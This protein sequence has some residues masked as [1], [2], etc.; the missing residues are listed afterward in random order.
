MHSSALLAEATQGTRVS[1]HRS[2]ICG[3]ICGQ[4]SFE[5]VCQYSLQQQEDSIGP[6]QYGSTVKARLA[7]NVKGTSRPVFIVQ[8]MFLEDSMNKLTCTIKSTVYLCSLAPAVPHF[9]HALK[10]SSACPTIAH[11][12]IQAVLL[13]HL[14]RRIWCAAVMR[15]MV[16]SRR[17]LWC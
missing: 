17:L 9:H 4:G 5:N 3:P 11:A 1:I 13:R 14:A 12:C 6:R 2:I 10:Q 8:Q 16:S 15:K 7:S